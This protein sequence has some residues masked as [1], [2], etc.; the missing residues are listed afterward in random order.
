M[1]FRSGDDADKSNA[2][3]YHVF[4]CYEVNPIYL[5]ADTNKENPIYPIINNVYIPSFYYIDVKDIRLLFLNSEITLTTCKDWYK[6]TY[7]AIQAAAYNATL[8]GAKT[9]NDNNAETGKNYTDEEANNYNATLEGALPLSDVIVNVYTGYG[10]NS[11]IYY[12]DKLGFNTIYTM[13]YHMT[14]DTSKRYIEICH[15]MPYTVITRDSLGWNPG[16]DRKSVV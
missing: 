6:T 4:Y 10:I 15:E 7:S 9:I 8:E 13:L 14:E 12:A 3:F 1:L 16:T 2:Y 11:N 5:T